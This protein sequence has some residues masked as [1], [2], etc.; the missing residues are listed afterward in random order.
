MPRAPATSCCSTKPIPARRNTPQSHH[1]WQPRVS[2]P[3]PSISVRAAR[4][5][6]LTR[7]P[8]VCR[9]PP[10]TNRQSPI[11]SPLSIGHCPS[12]S[13]SFSGAAATRLPWCLRL[14]QSMPTR[15]ARSSRFSPGE[16]LKD[17]GSVARAAAR[18]RA[19]IYV[20][21][22]PEAEE[23]RAS[24][25]ILAASPARVKTQYVPRFGLQCIDV[26]RGTRS[27]RRRRQL[28][29]CTCLLERASSTTVLTRTIFAAQSGIARTPPPASS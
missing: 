18:V 29:A 10:R 3:S 2:R 22:S 24:R 4:C 7:R 16:Y 15:S 9:S 6:A 21:S 23:V 13:R 28:D 25:A 26:N 11:S 17:R 20:T 5:T 8:L 14:Q 19:P 12:I 1:A 27:K